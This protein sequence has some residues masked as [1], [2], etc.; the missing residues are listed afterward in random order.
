[1]SVKSPC[2]GTCVLDPKSGFCLG[3]FRTGD[4]IG[5]WMG[6]SDGNKKRVISKAQSRQ[7]QFTAASKTAIST[8]S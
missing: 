5:A 6:L 7:V 1:M 2:I 3:C 8:N 4:E